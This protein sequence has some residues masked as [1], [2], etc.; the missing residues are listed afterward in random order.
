MPYCPECRDEFENWVEACPDCKVP[1]VAL[2]PALPETKK[3]D[4][5]LVKIATAPNEPIAKMWSGVLADHNIQCLLKGGNLGAAMYIPPMIL[6]HQL[7]VLESETAR[8]KELLS[9]FLEK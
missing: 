1:L 4:E 2:L 8:A 3:T 7:Y 9:P 6:P 5:P